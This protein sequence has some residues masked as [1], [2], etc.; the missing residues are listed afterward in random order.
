MIN[1]SLETLPRIKNMFLFVSLKIVKNALEAQNGIKIRTLRLGKKLDVLIKKK[2][3]KPI[4]NL[5]L[6]S[7]A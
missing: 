3:G 6:L 5:I 7:A 2:E 1:T 4:S